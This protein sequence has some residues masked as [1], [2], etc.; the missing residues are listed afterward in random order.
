LSS[1]IIVPNL[2]SWMSVIYE[3]MLLR[4]LKL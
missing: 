1:Y 4:Y 3:S 2:R